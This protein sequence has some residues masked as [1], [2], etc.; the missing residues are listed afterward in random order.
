MDRLRVRVEE[1]VKEYRYKDCDLHDALTVEDAIDHVLDRDFNFGP[2]ELSVLGEF[3]Y[4]ILVDDIK[5]GHA[6]A[7]SSK[8]V[9]PKPDTP[10]LWGWF[11]LIASAYLA[12]C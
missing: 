10:T 7:F 11:L 6:K 1:V 12:L 9:P 8:P 3:A 5:I 2:Y 4:D